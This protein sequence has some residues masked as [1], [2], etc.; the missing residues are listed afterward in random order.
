MSAAVKV[1]GTSMRSDGSDVRRITFP[2][3]PLYDARPDI[4]IDGRRI[5]FNRQDDTT[6]GIFSLTSVLSRP[7][8]NSQNGAANAGAHT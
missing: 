1:A 8:S 7:T 5:V 4:S 2:E 3:P 6:I